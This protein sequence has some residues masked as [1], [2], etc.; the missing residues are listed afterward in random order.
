VAKHAELKADLV[1]AAV[2]LPEKIKVAE[3]RLTPETTDAQLQLTLDDPE[4][5]TGSYSVFLRGTSKT[6]FERNPEGLARI[7]SRR[8]AMNDVIARLDAHVQQAADGLAGAQQHVARL[9]ALLSRFEGAPESV[10]QSL[11]VANA[12]VDQL[13]S[14][15]DALQTSAASTTPVSVSDRTP[16]SENNIVAALEKLAQEI[17]DATADM[18]LQFQHANA[19]AGQMA[20]QITAAQGELQAAQQAVQ[21]AEAA[22]RE[23]AQKRQRADEVVKQLDQQVAEA[24]KNFGAVEVAGYLHS[25]AF[26]LTVQRLPLVVQLPSEP[27][28]LQPGQTCE[29]PVTIQRRFGFAD[30]VDVT[31][32]APEGVAHLT[33][34]PCRIEGDS[35]EAVI[36]VKA[37]DDAPPGAVTPQVVLKLKF[38]D[39]ELQDTLPLKVTVTQPSS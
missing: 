31:L 34:E 16:S 11:Q 5:P 19:A 35:S 6:S 9:T 32:Q 25:P 12:Q 4:I 27:V 38:N 14:Q 20:Q 7:R 13:R 2:G 26:T 39:V 1:L 3:L 18:A 23:A 22:Q 36:V 17:T 24:E 30:A 33:A 37:A 28:Q 29:V 15:L 8:A 21:S 10:Q